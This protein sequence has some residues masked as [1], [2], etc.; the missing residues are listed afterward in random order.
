[1]KLCDK[2]KVDMVFSGHENVQ[3]VVKF[4]SVTYVVSGGGGTLLTQSSSE[5][6]FLNYV[7]VKV[8]YDYLDYEVRKVNPPIWEFFCYYMWKDLLYFVKSWMN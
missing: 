6:S 3:R 1:M 8:N 2:Y 5:G 7:A 4:G